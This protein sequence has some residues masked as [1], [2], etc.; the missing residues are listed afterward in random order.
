[1]VAML[2]RAIQKRGVIQ[3]AGSLPNVSILTSLRLQS[4]T[5]FLCGRLRPN[6]IY[7]PYPFPLPLQNK[8]EG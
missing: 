2:R 4:G 7:T 8:G 1:V 6:H 3:P 5:K